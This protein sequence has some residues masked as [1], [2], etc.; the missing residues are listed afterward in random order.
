MK[1]FYQQSLSRVLTNTPE[2]IALTT[3]TDRY[4]YAQLDTLCK[5][6]ANALSKADIKPGSRIGIYLPKQ[7]ETVV[8]M[9]GANLHGAVFVIINPALKADQVDYIVRHCQVQVLISHQQRI[10]SLH[11]ETL[12]TIDAVVSTDSTAPYSWQQLIDGEVKISSERKADPAPDGLA[13]II[14]TSGST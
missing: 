14:Y 9:L 7:I 3:K 6:F 5:A 13:S 2:A 10:Q 11:A 12:D 4:S 8:A 1:S